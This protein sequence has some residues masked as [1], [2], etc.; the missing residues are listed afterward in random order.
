MKDQSVKIVIIPGL[1][2]SDEDHWQSFWLKEFEN[3]IRVVQN[4][5]DK[6][7]LNDWLN[8]LNEEIIKLDSPTI[9]VAHSL[10]VSLVLHWVKKYNN[11]NIK[12]ALLVAPADV[13]SPTHTPEIVRGF[14]AIPISKI[15]FPSVVVASENDEFVSLQ[16]AKYFSEQW[17]SEFI[18]VG[19][20]GHI[21][22][23]SN[24]KNWKEG[25]NILNKLIKNA[26]Y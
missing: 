16:R 21:N 19:F 26:C 17:G 5:W 6:P 1:G 3:S 8:K 7:I 22:S 10:A 4:D 15:S 2:G 20:K 24:L 25:K 18:N 13:D 9:L 11:P 14:S 12:G 23:D